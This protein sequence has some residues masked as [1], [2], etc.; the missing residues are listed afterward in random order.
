MA[1]LSRSSEGDAPKPTIAFVGFM[2]AGKTRAAKGA[3]AVLGEQVV[4]VDARIEEHFGAPAD[5][6][7][8]ARGEAAFRDVEER[9]A[10]DA[11][12]GG[13]LVAL[14]GGAVASERI[15]AALELLDGVFARPEVPASLELHMAA[16][17][18][19][20]LR[21][22][23]GTGNVRIAAHITGGGLEGNLPR[24]LPDHLAAQV[25]VGSW[26]VPD[27]QSVTAQAALMVGASAMGPQPF[28]ITPRKDETEDEARERI[29]ERFE[30]IGLG[31]MNRTGG[32]GPFAENPVAA[33]L[34]DPAK[35]TIAAQVIGQAYVAAYN[36]VQANR[37]AVAHIAD[38][39]SA[40]RELFGDELLELL[41]ES[42]LEIT[43]VDL[44]EESSWPTM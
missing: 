10:V 14:G 22:A 15:R 21:A 12:A 37:E 9:V 43:E 20:E 1:A 8:S 25:D 5:E 18:D 26:P 24:V 11:L 16:R 44:A 3:G 33:V 30:K 27:V 35:R 36:L 23:F 34:G 7:F 19:P 2:G 39:L 32:G 13:G 4:D 40:R 38:V 29:L 17:T 28:D 6:V 41:E 31:I 42:K